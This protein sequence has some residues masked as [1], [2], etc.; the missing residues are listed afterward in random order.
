MAMMTKTRQTVVV[1]RHGVSSPDE[2][3]VLTQTVRRGDRLV[4]HPTWHLRAV[5]PVRYAGTLF[6]TV[7]PVAGDTVGNTLHLAFSMT[8]KLR[9]QQWLERQPG[10]HA[11]H[12]R[13]MVTK[14]GMPVASLD[15][16]ITRISQ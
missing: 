14:L 12:N 2:T 15:D 5:A 16:I 10:G 3:V 7:G 13:P 1:E 11:S 9:A 8:G 4:V 6:D